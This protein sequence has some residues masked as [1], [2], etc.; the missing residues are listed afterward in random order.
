MPKTELKK[1]VGTRVT[2]GNDGIRV[3]YHDTQVF[4]AQGYHIALNHGGFITKTTK[5]RMNQ[6]AEEFGYKFRVY[7]KKGEMYARLEDGES[8]KFEGNRL[9]IHE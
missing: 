7:S 5:S 2:N 8:V 6:S 3:S 1:L 9:T 4:H